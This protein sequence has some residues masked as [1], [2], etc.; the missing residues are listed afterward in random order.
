[1][2]LFSSIIPGL[3][4]AWFPIVF[5]TQESGISQVTQCFVL[6]PTHNLGSSTKSCTARVWVR[7]LFWDIVGVNLIAV[8]RTALRSELSMSSRVKLR[9]KFWFQGLGTLWGGGLGFC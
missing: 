7:V 8:W 4:G 2:I 3:Q 1:M 9:V 5:L 6:P